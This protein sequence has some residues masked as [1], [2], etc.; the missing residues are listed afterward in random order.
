MYK[1]ENVAI[2]YDDFKNIRFLLA[3]EM[4]PRLLL[5]LLDDNYDLNGFR[6]ILDKPSASVLHGLNEL[7]ALNLIKKN[8]KSYA[9]TSKGILYA[10]ALKKLFRDLYIFRN[11]T[12]FWQD[13]SIESIPAY[14][15]RNSYLLKDSVFV[16]SD[17]ENLSKSSDKIIE[18]LS[19]CDDMRI[20]LPIFL[21]DYLEK[22]LDNLEKGHNLLLITNEL[23]LDSLKESKYYDELFKYSKCDQLII[24]KVEEELQIFLT[25]CDNG[26]ALSLFFNDGLFDN[27]CVIFNDNAEGI[28]WSNQLFDFYLKKSIKII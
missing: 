18:L 11:R 19:S 25:V 3:S 16:E 21:E 15:F 2:R 22:I 8:F 26:M 5:L 13:H 24:K 12:D 10:L 7:E 4:R 28:K 23:V 14:F 27:S 9:L 20:I 1:E 17:E 6:D